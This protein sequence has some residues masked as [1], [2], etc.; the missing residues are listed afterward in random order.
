VGRVKTYESI[1]KGEN[2]PKPG[3]PESFKVLIKELQSLGMD[4]KILSGDMQEISIE[5]N[6]DDDIDEISI[7]ELNEEMAALP[8]NEDMAGHGFSEVDEDDMLIEALVGG[9]TTSVMEEDDD[10]ADVDEFDDIDDED[11]DV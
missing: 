10:Y 11:D 6:M 8:G 1:V 9:N 2:V 3:I 7:D 5:E 4:V